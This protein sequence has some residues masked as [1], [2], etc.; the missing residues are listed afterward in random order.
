MKFLYLALT[1]D[2][3][4]LGLFKTSE[5]AFAKSERV[6]E[7]QIWNLNEKTGQFHPSNA[8]VGRLTLLPKRDEV[9]S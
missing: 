6:H 2:G 5:Q 3:K 4:Q 1:K 9:K 7:C 8:S